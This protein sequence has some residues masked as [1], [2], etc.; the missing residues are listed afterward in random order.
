[1]VKNNYDTATQGGDE[2]GNGKGVNIMLHSKF[3]ALNLVKAMM[4]ALLFFS[5]LP[6]SNA[7][8]V[9]TLIQ[10]LKDKDR[11]VRWKAAW[12]L[13]TREYSCR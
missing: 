7:D 5:C 3:V 10:K 1:M 6:S 2:G 13:G 4:V 8:E 11:N 12:T 9:D